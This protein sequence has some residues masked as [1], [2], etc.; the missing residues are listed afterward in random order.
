MRVVDFI[1]IVKEAWRAYD[2]SRPIYQITDISVQVST[3]HV[4]KIDLEGPHFVVAKLSYF[5]KFEHFVEDHTLINVL[6]NNLGSPFQNF[7]SRSLVKGNEV[8]TYRYTQDPVDVWV[9]FY[10]PIRVDQKLPKKLDGWQI[11][12]LG[13]QFAMLHK[14]CGR[15]RNTLPKWSKTLTYDLEHLLDILKTEV[16]QF[17]HRGHEDEIRRQVDLFMNNVDRLNHKSFQLIPVFIDWNIGNFSVTDECE[18]YSR[19]D[20]DWFRIGPRVLDF[21]FL[22]R[23]VREEGD[24][25]VFSYHIDTLM[26]DR[27][28]RFLRAYH[29]INPLTETEVIFMK[30]AYRF[31]ILN[32]VIKDGRYFYH[33]LYATKLQHEAYTNYFPRLDEVFDA[34][35][36]LRALDMK[37]PAR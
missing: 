14:E 1:Q 3:N 9:V 7:I 15:V 16:G 37:T 4:Y 18:L 12:K 5:G 31:F 30:E 28:L 17:V 33:E 20:Y 26:E 34:D 29:T 11:D 21:Y 2:D 23:V 6:A 35:R 24:Q 36:I 22:S 32:Y 19:W 10:N 13:Q 27:F 25:T 8:F